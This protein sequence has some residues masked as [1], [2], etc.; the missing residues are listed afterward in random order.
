MDTPEFLLAIPPSCPDHPFAFGF[1][2]VFISHF[3]LYLMIYLL[4]LFSHS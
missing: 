2:A 3:S 4:F 1:I